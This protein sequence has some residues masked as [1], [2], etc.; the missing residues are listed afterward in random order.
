M[1]VRLCVC[2]CVLE[3]VL[4]CLCVRVRVFLCVR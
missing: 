4:V 3:S 1:S 2:L